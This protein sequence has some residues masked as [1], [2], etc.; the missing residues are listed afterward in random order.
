MRVAG[1]RNRLA[2]VRRDRIESTPPA[3]GVALL[4]ASFAGFAYARHRHDTYAVCV[5]DRGLQGFDYRG[6]AW[7]SAPG[8]VVVLHPDE[9]HDGRAAAPEG[10]GYRIVYVAPEKIGAAARALCGVHVPLPFVRDPVLT[11][12]ALTGPVLTGPVPAGAALA[13]AVADA[14]H[15]FPAPLEPL[16]VDAVIEALARGLVAADPAIRRKRRRNPCDPLA[17]ARA[18]DFLDAEKSR[19]VSSAELEAVSGHDR[20]S[21]ARAFREAYGTS[22]YRYLLMRRLDG[23]REG[24]LAGRGLAGIALDA[25]FADQAHLSRMFKAAF[26]LSPAKFRAAAV[27]ASPA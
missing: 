24:I 25:G 4:C 1:T 5:T 13:R 8:Q 17:L 19:V 3:G 23:V 10:F 12:L 15:D 2:D 14:F 21:L 18:R 11:G 20:Y 9:P 6:A 26:G 22:P 27:A 7:T 16:A